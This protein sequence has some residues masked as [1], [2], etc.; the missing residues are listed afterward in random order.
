MVVLT[1]FRSASYTT[2]GL[3]FLTK[4]ILGNVHSVSA[5]AEVKSLPSGCQSV[6]L[7]YIV[8]GRH[9]LISWCVQVVFD[10][11]NGQLNETVVYTNEAIRPVFLIIFG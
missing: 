4:V 10:R 9:G 1:R 6:S 8:C 3:M 7:A 5:F 2:C 11:M